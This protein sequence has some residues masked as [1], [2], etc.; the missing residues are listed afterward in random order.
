M[1]YPQPDAEKEYLK[2]QLGNRWLRLLSNSQIFN[3]FAD[4]ATQE[5]KI[6]R[7]KI[8]KR[9]RIFSSRDES[10]TAFWA[11]L[12]TRFY[13]EG[14]H[15]GLRK[16][17]EDGVTYRCPPQYFLDFKALCRSAPSYKNTVLWVFRTDYLGGWIFAHVLCAGNKNWF[18][19]SWPDA[20]K[21]QGQRYLVSYYPAGAV[22][23]LSDTDEEFDEAS[24]ENYQNSHS[25]LC[26]M[27]N[28]QSPAA[29]NISFVDYTSKNIL[30]IIDD[31]YLGVSSAGFGD[32]ALQ[33][34]GLCVREGKISAQSKLRQDVCELLE[35]LA[36]DYSHLESAIIDDADYMHLMT[37]PLMPLS[38]K[39]SYGAVMADFESAMKIIVIENV[40][41]IST[42]V[43]GL[44]EEEDELCL[45]F[46]RESSDN[47]ARY[48]LEI[49]RQYLAK[50]PTQDYMD[51]EGFDAL[52]QMSKMIKGKSSAI[53]RTAALKKIV[54]RRTKKLTDYVEATGEFPVTGHLVVALMEVGQILGNPI[55]DYGDLIYR[56][57]PDRPWLRT[58]VKFDGSVNH[59][60]E[61]V[62]KEFLAFCRIITGK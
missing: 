12:M 56:T 49:V 42:M 52:L 31:P 57:T 5:S 60:E 51:I 8:V 55:S 45:Y 38:K 43:K 1:G 61:D 41:E 53:V 27:F 62:R 13:D 25:L 3:W 4:Y 59:L 32:A 30:K 14:A 33:I 47:D 50:T 9:L 11:V 48:P 37:Y 17:V 7:D 28:T 39:S 35:N 21:L 22:N 2:T 20:L 18:K 26:M 23:E 16:Y 44:K 29:F 34:A 24:L 46:E 15:L 40:E 10:P 19:K 36:K 6:D 54:H 58:S